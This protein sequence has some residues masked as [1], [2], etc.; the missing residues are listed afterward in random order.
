MFNPRF[1]H[2]LVVKRVARDND[3][4][5]IYD[6]KG[7]VSYNDVELELVSTLDGEPMRNSDGSFV[8]TTTTIMPFG[9]RTNSK[10]TSQRL[11]VVV[12]DYKLACPMFLGELLFDDVIIV[13]DYDRTFVGRLIKK[14]TYNWGTN[15]WIDEV[16]N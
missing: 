15:V 2:S 4:E 11:D 8:T 13:T 10:N 9:Y 1:P 7:D 6:E 3:G 5:I 12:S 16:R 14:M